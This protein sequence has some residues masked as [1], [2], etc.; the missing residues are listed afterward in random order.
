VTRSAEGSVVVANGHTHLI[1]AAK[2]PKV[3]DTTGAGDLYA[4]GFLFGYTTGR[5]LEDCSRLGN[6][7]AGIVIGQIG[8]RPLVSLAS[9]A[10]EAALV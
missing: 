5:S 4:S 6:L 9:A 2:V 7:S 10:R 3:V 8:P 1:E